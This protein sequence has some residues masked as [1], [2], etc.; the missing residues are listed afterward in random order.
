MRHTVRC[1]T[2]IFALILSSGGVKADDLGAVGSLA[3]L[4]VSTP[5]GDVY[6]QYHG[7]LFVKNSN[8]T[9]DEYRWGGTSCG[10][11]VLTDAEVALLQRALNHKKMTIEP[12]T[13]DG[14]G[15]AKC[16]VGFTL[17][18]KKNLKLFP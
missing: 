7:R 18:E 12:R 9:L 15:G 5:F 8:G 16:L 14:Q 2:F 13:Q 4:D 11:K 17:V 6:L 10:T 3:A 1:L